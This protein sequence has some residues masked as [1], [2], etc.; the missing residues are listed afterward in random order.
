MASKILLKLI[1]EAILPAIFTVCA[2]ILSLA[3]IIYFAQI[4]WR[5]STVGNFPTII[6]A[7]NNDLIFVNS[8]SN[9]IMFLIIVL[10]L[11]WILTRAHIF[12]D[13]HISPSLTLRL[14]SWDLTE[15]LTTSFNIYQ[16]SVIWFAFLWLALLFLGLQVLLGIS[17]FWIFV[18]AAVITVFLTWLL[19]EDIERE[20]EIRD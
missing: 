7:S 4:P 20:L 3:V 1:D 11:L 6:F 19:V 2:K 12:H 9:L 13:T 17:Y 15:L 16:K 10:G 5:L 14:L 8:Y 18:I